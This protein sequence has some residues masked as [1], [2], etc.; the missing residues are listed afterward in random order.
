MIPAFGRFKPLTPA[1][2]RQRG[3][4]GA[5]QMQDLSVS[6]EEQRE[7]GSNWWLLPVFGSSRFPPIFDS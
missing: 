4:V 1:L 5:G 3:R 6:D 2:A 7:V